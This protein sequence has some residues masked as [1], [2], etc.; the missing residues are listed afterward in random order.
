M[1]SLDH[2]KEERG[3]WAFLTTPSGLV[4]IGFLLVAGIYL[5]TEHRAHLLGVLVWLPLTACALMHLFHG[6]DH[7]SH[8]G[9]RS[10]PSTGGGNDP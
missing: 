8:P 1:S 3:F 5:W 10:A 9:A 2:V 6:H 7:R 4:L